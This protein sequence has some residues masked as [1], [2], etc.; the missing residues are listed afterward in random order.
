MLEK[1]EKDR[2]IIKAD[3]FLFLWHG[4]RKVFSALRRTRPGRGHSAAEPP[5]PHDY[6]G[7]VRYFPPCGGRGPKYKRKDS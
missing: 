3:P 6:T 4:T 5:L 1:E 2:H 7:R